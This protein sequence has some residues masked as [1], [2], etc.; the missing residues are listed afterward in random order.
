MKEVLVSCFKLK[1]D[2]LSDEQ[3]KFE[4][5]KRISK[6]VKDLLTDVQDFS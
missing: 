5:E 3:V 1:V 2:S 4:F 6:Q